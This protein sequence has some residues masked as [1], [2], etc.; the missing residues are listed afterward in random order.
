M[1]PLPLAVLGL[2]NFP[3]ISAVICIESTLIIGDKMAQPLQQ[4][5]VN[6]QVCPLGNRY[7]IFEIHVT[8]LQQVMKLTGS[9][10]IGDSN[11]SIITSKLVFLA[12]YL[13]ANPSLLF[14]CHI[15]LSPP[16]YGPFHSLMEHPTVLTA[17]FILYLFI[18]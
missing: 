2:T 13:S 18:T 14:L 8:L 16:L 1:I 17:C 7:H 5:V 12:E 3:A 4:C 9:S 10:P 11:I 15:L 6:D